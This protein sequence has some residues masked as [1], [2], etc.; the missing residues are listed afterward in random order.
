MAGAQPGAVFRILMTVGTTGL[1]GEAAFL[2]FILRTGVWGA[3]TWD[4]LLAEI[5]LAGFV[6][7]SILALVI[8]ARLKPDL[9][10]P[11]RKPYQSEADLGHRARI[12]LALAVVL[13]VFEVGFQLAL[14]VI[15]LSR[16]RCGPL[17]C[18]AWL[19]C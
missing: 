5:G 10:F 14:L 19:T 9:A 3:T 4:R 13:L 15:G 17:G 7:G 11:P 16:P 12:L 18:T 6:Y 2:A 8:F 1:F